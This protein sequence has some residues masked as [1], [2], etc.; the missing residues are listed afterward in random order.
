MAYWTLLHDAG[1]VAL[2]FLIRPRENADEA[3]RVDRAICA[4]A[5]LPRSRVRVSAVTAV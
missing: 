2:V 1:I 3:T 4:P 5:F